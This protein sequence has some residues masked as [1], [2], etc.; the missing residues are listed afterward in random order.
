MG[1][2]LNVWKEVVQ[3]LSCQNRASAEQECENE[4]FDR[5]PGTHGALMTS[6][7]HPLKMS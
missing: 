4:L 2:G 6:A 5:C 3:K 7:I 1:V